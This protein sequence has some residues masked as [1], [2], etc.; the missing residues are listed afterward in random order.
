[1]L[2]INAHWHHF[3]KV[4]WRFLKN[5]TA[6]VTGGSGWLPG[7]GSYVTLVPPEGSETH[8]ANTFTLIVET[9]TG[10]CGAKCNTDPITETQSLSFELKGPL[11]STSRV[12]LWCSSESVVFAKQPDVT[13]TKG[14]L[15]LSMKP[16]TICTATTLL[17]R[18]TYFVFVLGVSL[19]LYFG[20]LKC[21]CSS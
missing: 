20:V 18:H 16:D 12:A 8:P 5:A 3:S 21:F 19:A 14:M 9:L 11:A 10:T 1:M 15:K 4:G 7:G 2:W 17:V 6:E 13:V